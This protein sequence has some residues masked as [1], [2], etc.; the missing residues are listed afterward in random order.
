[1]LLPGH[2]VRDQHRRTPARTFPFLLDSAAAFTV[3]NMDVVKAVLPADTAV[4]AA[5]KVRING[6]VTQVNLATA[7]Y[8]GLNI[9]GV[10]FFK[11]N[12]G[13]LTVDYKEE[14]ATFQWVPCLQFMVERW[15]LTSCQMPVLQS[16]AY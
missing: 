16:A 9:L 4:P 7:H 11:Q 5:F 3:V 15:Y 13:I 10:N 12:N 1:M 6:Q 2:A 14:M 8:D